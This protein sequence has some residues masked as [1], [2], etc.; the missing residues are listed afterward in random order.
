[1]KKMKKLLFMTLITFNSFGQINYLVI[2][3]VMVSNDTALVDEYGEFDDWIEIYNNG[4]NSINLFGYHLSDDEAELEKYSFPSIDLNPDEYLIIW[5]DD[6]YD[7]QGVFHA[8]F[9]MSSAG[10]SLFFTDPDLNIIDQVEWGPMEAD[11]AYARV[12]N[13]VG[14]FMIQQHTFGANNEGPTS[15]LLSHNNDSK[16]IINTINILG[17]KTNNSVNIYLEIHQDYSVSKK[18]VLNY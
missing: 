18:A 8:N 10:E 5:A 14:E 11:I 1:M 17:Q 12:P 6:G 4:N 9:K 3:E 16:K 13:G 2:N 7:K 15:S